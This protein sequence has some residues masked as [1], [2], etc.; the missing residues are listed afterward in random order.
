MKALAKFLIPIGNL[1]QGIHEYDYLL[2]DAFFNHFE[3]SP[4]KEGQVNLKLYLDRRSSMMELNFLFE[5]KMKSECDRCLETFQ[6]P[7]KGESNLIVKFSE[8][9]QE[10]EDI[11]IIYLLKNEKDF[12]ISNY[13]YEF[14]LLTLPISKYHEDA[15]EDCDEK[16]MKIL[17]DQAPK[18]EEKPN[19]PFGDALKNF[20]AN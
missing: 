18:V 12:D 5:G 17:E 2:D 13:V 10:S 15:D 7:I 14:A 8:V 1:K 19:N 20:N 6:F 11:D 16:I 3:H 4:I 9:E